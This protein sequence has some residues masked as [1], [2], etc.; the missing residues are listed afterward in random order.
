MDGLVQLLQEASTLQSDL[1]ENVN[2]AASPGPLHIKRF[3][4]KHSY[5]PNNS[6]KLLVVRSFSYF[7]FFVVDA[8]SLCFKV[9]EL[10]QE[11]ICKMKP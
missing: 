1:E 8:R 9:Q 4:H 6:M 2:R 11:P 5:N 10:M 7:L 3:F